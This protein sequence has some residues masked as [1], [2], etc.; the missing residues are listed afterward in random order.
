MKTTIAISAKHLASGMQSTKA[1]IWAF[2]RT[3]FD[4]F[5]FSI[6]IVM[7]ASSAFVAGR[8]ILSWLWEN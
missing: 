6:L 4:V 2:F 3:A 8:M 5:C 1:K 7:L